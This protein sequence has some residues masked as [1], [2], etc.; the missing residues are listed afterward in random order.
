MTCDS[1]DPADEADAG[2]CDA[3]P[4]NLAVPIL[5][6]PTSAPIH[7]TV[8][9]GCIPVSYDP[10]VAQHR[11]DFEAAL[12]AW[13]GI[14]CS[15]LCFADPIESAEVPAPSAEARA[16]HIGPAATVVPE[17]PDFSGATTTFENDTG[18]IRVAY[19]GLQNPDIPMTPAEWAH[20]LGS[21]LGLG[22]A[23]AGTDS[24]LAADYDPTGP[25]T[26]TDADQATLCVLYGDS[27]L[28]TP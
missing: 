8:A 28:C 15:S 23:A 10:A 20:H 17:N 24:L 4:G 9:G 21:A 16:I 22:E 2:I 7:W 3:I 14:A 18:T 6:T 12:T 25:A 26:P 5:Q 19:L 11:A 1:T 13:E 27:P